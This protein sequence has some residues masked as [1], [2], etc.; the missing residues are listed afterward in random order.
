MGCGLILLFS[1]GFLYGIKLSENTFLLFLTFFDLL[2]NAGLKLKTKKARRLSLFFA[3]VT[4]KENNTIEPRIPLANT[5]PTPIPNFLFPQPLTWGERI[6]LQL[7]IFCLL[8]SDA[9]EPSV[10][11]VHKA[12]VPMTWSGEPEARCFTWSVSLAWSAGNNCLLAKSSTSS[13]KI[14]SFAKRIIWTANTMVSTV[15]ICPW[16]SF[17][18][19][20]RALHQ[21]NLYRPRVFLWIHEFWRAV[22][23][24]SNECC[25]TQWLRSH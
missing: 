9:L 24:I 22:T 14:N 20:V 15:K 4:W 2:E 25:Q 3:F 10:V 13:M 19:F 16:I 1:C 23:E 18:K 5:K 7:L 21:Q 17:G 8:P 12:S 6:L 11:V